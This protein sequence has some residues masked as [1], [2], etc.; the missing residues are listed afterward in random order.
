[1]VAVALG[2][3]GVEERGDFVIGDESFGFRVGGLN[4]DEVAGSRID[5]G[6]G[7]AVGGPGDAFRWIAGERAGVSE[8]Y[9]DGPGVGLSAQGREGKDNKQRRKK[10]ER[11]LRSKQ[12]SRNKP[13][14]GRSRDDCVKENSKPLGR[15]NGTN[16]CA[17]AGPP[18]LRFFMRKTRGIMQTVPMERMAMTSR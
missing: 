7:F 16:Q 17:A 15:K 11:I 13:G 6:G 14:C 2:N 12:V 5:P 3:R 18:A 1:V 4:L 10:P 9:L 8:D